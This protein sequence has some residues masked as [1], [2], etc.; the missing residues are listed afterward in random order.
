[1]VELTVPFE[2]GM[3]EATKRAIY[4]QLLGACAAS[5]RTAHIITIYPIG[6]KS[7]HECLQS[8]QAVTLPDTR[9]NMK[10]KELEQEIMQNSIVHFH[11]LQRKTN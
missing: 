7:N 10:C 6:I 3:A 1:M 11:V 8:H 5:Y 9:R 4:K 2:V